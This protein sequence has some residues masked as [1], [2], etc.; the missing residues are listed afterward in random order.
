MNFFGE[1]YNIE[2]LLFFFIIY[3]N[4]CMQKGINHLRKDVLAIVNQVW[5]ICLFFITD[6]SDPATGYSAVFLAV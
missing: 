4:Y 2:I 5:S 3:I 6:F 1:K